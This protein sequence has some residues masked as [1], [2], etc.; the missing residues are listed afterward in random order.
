MKCP[1][2]HAEVEPGSL[3]CGK[4]L[5]EVPWVK[6][7]DSVETRLAKKEIEEQSA[8]GEEA[9]PE[10][11][12]RKFRISKRG[13]LIAGIA[14]G[15]L[16]LLLVFWEIFSFSGRY[17]A[18]Q[19]AYAAGDYDKAMRRIQGALDWEPESLEANL[20]LAKI[21]HGDGDSESAEMVLTPMLKAYPDSVQ[22]YRLMFEILEEEGK[23][24]TIKRMMGEC[25]S[26][27]VLEECG[28]YICEPPVC[29]LEEGTYT[30]AQALTLSADYE[31]IYYT[32]DGSVPTKG[33]FRY[34]GEILLSEEGAVQLRAFGINGKGIASD[35]V[36]WDFV[37]ALEKPEA[38]R[39]SPKSGTF[40][41]ST[42]IVVNV[43]EGYTAY[44]AFDKEPSVDGT[45]YEHPVSMP[46]GEHTFYVM[47]VSANGS[48]SDVTSADYYLEY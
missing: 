38:P 23:Y 20:L 25:E 16:I 14:F 13:I 15:V 32:L 27:E 33:A 45:V 8:S 12:P 7:F 30:T 10:K 35:V 48:V 11:A 4:C 44:Y 28:E 18:A 24:A 2:C 6:E 34:E 19:M 21:L 1:K 43:P 31:E 3:Y 42:D 17:R 37:I 46:M 22:V 40:T 39:V 9:A 5:T 36:T 41:E 29:S 26:E 47:L